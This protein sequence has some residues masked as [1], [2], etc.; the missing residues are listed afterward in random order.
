[1][2]QMRGNF[3]RGGLLLQN[4]L[5]IP[6]A[7]TLET[8]SSRPTDARVHVHAKPE[9]EGRG[10]RYGEA[11]ISRSTTWETGKFGGGLGKSVKVRQEVGKSK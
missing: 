11:D 4:Y 9:R 10:R 1:M 8:N 2:E 5:N 6:S 7:V 3:Q